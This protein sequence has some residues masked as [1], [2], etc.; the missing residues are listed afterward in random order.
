MNTP[1]TSPTQYLVRTA[2]FH[3]KRIAASR[4][5]RLLR[6]PGGFEGLGVAGVVPHPNLA[7]IFQLDNLADM[8]V[9]R[10]ATAFA[11]CRLDREHDHPVFARVDQSL[12][13]NR[14]V[15]EFR[16]PG[17]DELDE[18]LAAAP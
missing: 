16:G 5:K 17:A 3:A 4:P 10:H 8:Q 7:A 15:V 1:A 11:R 14:P 12:K 6:Q 18:P 2:P 9:D 13:S